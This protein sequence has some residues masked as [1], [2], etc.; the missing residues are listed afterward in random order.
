MSAAA[1]PSPAR[2]AAVGW[3]ARLAL[4]DAAAF[5]PL[6]Q[7][8]GRTL[9]AVVAIALGVALGFAVYLINRV[10]AEEVQGASRSLFGLADLA[11]QAPGAGFDEALFPRI[12][13]LPGVAVASPVVEVQVRL[14]GRERNLKLIGIDPFRAFR[15]QPALAG[16]GSPAQR[17]G[18]GL[19]AP[20]ALWLSPAAAQAL[21]LTAG[22]TLDVQVALDRVSFE[23]AGILPPGAY[24]Q[25]VG[26]LDIGA[27][28][29]RL[30]RL[31]RLDR[32]DL[33]LEP[34]ANRAAVRAAIVALL[35]P[36]VQV[37]TPGE[38]TE[39]AVRLTRAYRSNLTALALVALF[40]GAFLV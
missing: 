36:G 29:W 17:E 11:V 16:A 24:R 31:G 40:T 26:L 38:A 12:A 39:D 19:L 15:L 37:V 2:P 14:P 7:V 4:L 22:D 1:A 32:I 28:Q 25:A 21:E 13:E 20:Q 33:R 8:P 18:Q 5:G 6:R 3:R 30:R 9:L 10:A 34:R 35:P 23:V 27:A